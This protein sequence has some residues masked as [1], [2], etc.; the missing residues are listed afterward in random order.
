MRRTGVDDL[1]EAYA[2]TQSG[3]RLPSVIFQKD[4]VDFLRDDSAAYFDDAE[5]VAG[6]LKAKNFHFKMNDRG[7]NMYKN[8]DANQWQ[9]KR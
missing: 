7:Y 2:D 8:P 9:N 5:R 4:L 1:L 6:L 3:G